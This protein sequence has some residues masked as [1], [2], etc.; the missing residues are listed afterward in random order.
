MKS[1][2]RQIVY[3]V[4]ALACVIGVLVVADVEDETS[5]R[6]ASADGR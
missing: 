6:A 2:W 1:I 5:P 3:F 4:V